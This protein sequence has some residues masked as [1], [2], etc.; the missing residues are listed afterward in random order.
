MLR[1]FSLAGA[2]GPRVHVGNEVG[3]GS[4]MSMCSSKCGQVIPVG[5]DG[6]CVHVGSEVG[7]GGLDVHAQQQV[8]SGR[9]AQ[10]HAQQAGQARASVHPDASHAVYFRTE[11]VIQLITVI[12]IKLIRLIKYFYVATSNLKTR[13]TMPILRP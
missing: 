1:V 2:G 4:P 3:V 6:P 10:Q 12:I 7:V 11:G 8:R 13:S 5:V 9:Q